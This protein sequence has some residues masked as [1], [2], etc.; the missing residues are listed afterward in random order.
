VSLYRVGEEA[1]D[2][3]ELVRIPFMRTALCAGFPSPA[4][5]LHRGCPRTLPL[6]CSQLR[7]HLHLARARLVQEE[8]RHHLS[9]GGICPRLRWDPARRARVALHVFGWSGGPSPP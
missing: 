9:V 8:R 7:R 2:R 6:A 4:E 5:G 3:S 1:I